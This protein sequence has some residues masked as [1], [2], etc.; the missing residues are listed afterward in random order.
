MAVNGWICGGCSGGDGA[1]R[2]ALTLLTCLACALAGYQVGDMK[3]LAELDEWSRNAG[4]HR[5][6]TIQ[7]VCP[8]DVKYYEVSR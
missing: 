8:P 5:F 6:K 1:V 3:S 4:V 2:A 7:A